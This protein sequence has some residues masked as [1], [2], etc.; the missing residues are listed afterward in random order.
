[1][2]WQF[3]WFIFNVCRT[4]QRSRSLWIEIRHTKGLGSLSILSSLVFNQLPSEILLATG[5]P[6]KQL[7]VYCLDDKLQQGCFVHRRMKK[8]FS[9]T[10]FFLEKGLRNFFS[11]I[12]SSRP[13]P[14]GIPLVSW[15]EWRA[16]S[17][18]NCPWSF[19]M[20]SD[21]RACPHP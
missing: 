12:S 1:M 14:P 6:V 11:S 4:I 2:P 17:I 5:R 21:P 15:K 10:L 18:K 20:T 9:Q 8:I 19:P 7:S 13:P 3:E 16:L